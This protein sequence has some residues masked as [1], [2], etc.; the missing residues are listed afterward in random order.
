M[1]FGLPGGKQQN[2][3]LGNG[4]SAPKGGGGANRGTTSPTAKGAGTRTAA[5]RIR[6][7]PTPKAN[8]SGGTTRTTSKA[9]ERP[10]TTRTARTTASSP[11]ARAT[12]RTNSCR[13]ECLSVCSQICGLVSPGRSIAAFHLFL[14]TRFVQPAN[15]QYNPRCPYS[16]HEHSGSKTP[17]GSVLFQ[18]T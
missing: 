14:A 18:R 10:R 17:H 13:S 11:A 16:V 3:Q 5:N 1:F 15:H 2:F 6:V 4:R 12:A 8:A 7:V 9:R